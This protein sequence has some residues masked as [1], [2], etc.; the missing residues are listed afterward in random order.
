MLNSGANPH[1]V[2]GLKQNVTFFLAREGKPKVLRLLFK[3]YKVE[4]NRVDN[5]G[6]TAIFYASLKN[7]V[8]A[9]KVLVEFGGNVSHQDTLL[10]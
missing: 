1:F 10:Q 4:A 7:Q 3:E 9:L 5:N 6:Q 2:D 8:E